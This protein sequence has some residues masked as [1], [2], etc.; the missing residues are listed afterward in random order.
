MGTEPRDLHDDRFVEFLCNQVVEAAGEDTL[1]R[2][3][4]LVAGDE[5]RRVRDRRIRAGEDRDPLPRHSRPHVVV[6]G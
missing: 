5:G 4:A 6:P 2:Q 3:T 1:A